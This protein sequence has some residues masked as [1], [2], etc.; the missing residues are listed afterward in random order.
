MILSPPCAALWVQNYNTQ[1]SLRGVLT[2]RGSGAKNGRDTCSQKRCQ[3]RPILS[4]FS[5]PSLSSVT[6]CHGGVVVARGEP[7]SGGVASCSLLAS[8]V[9]S[10]FGSSQS[11]SFCRVAHS[12]LDSRS[13]VSGG[14][15]SA[16]S[17]IIFPSHRCRRSCNACLIH[18]LT[19]LSLVSPL[20]TRLK[21]LVAEIMEAFCKESH[22][23]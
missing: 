1:C 7:C 20:S 12:S 18:S 23:K 9:I 14:W 22:S 19:S 8:R 15:K 5:H 10:T 11:P 3:E 4:M 6:C 21:P 16:V 13:S 2:T 17:V